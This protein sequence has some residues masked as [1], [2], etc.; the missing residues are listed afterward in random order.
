MFYKSWFGSS[1]SF[2]IKVFFFFLRSSWI[3]QVNLQKCYIKILRGYSQL[4]IESFWLYHH[5]VFTKL[6]GYGFN[7]N[8]LKLIDDD[9]CER[10]QKN[11]L[12][13]TIYLSISKC[14]FRIIYGIPQESMLEPLLFN[15][16]HWN[17]FFES[18][19]SDFANY[20]DVMIPLLTNVDLH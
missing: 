1:F 11:Y 13:R 5:L 16:Y 17:L 7:G 2:I 19:R 6:N 20:A 8:A 3:V 4:F 10:S 14:L 15:I 9:L 18:Y 12:L